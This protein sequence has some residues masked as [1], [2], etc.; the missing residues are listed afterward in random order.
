MT[1]RPLSAPPGERPPARH[2]RNLLV[3]AATRRARSAPT[4]GRLARRRAMI[5]LTKWVLPACALALLTIV[6]IWPE[7]DRATDQARM[8]FR[9]L[10]AEVEGGRLVNARYRGVDE[11]DRPY[12]VTAATA[13]QVDP[14][15]IDMTMPKADIEMENGSWLMLQSRLGSY[16]QATQ[17]LELWQDVTL[18]RDDGTTLTTAAVSIDLKNGVAASGEPTHVEGPFGVLDAQGFTVI[19]K[20]EAIQFVGPAHVILNGASP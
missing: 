16:R 2:D 12:T 8:S 18:Y 5:T 10:T 6:A 15:R 13:R 20:G 3:D 9:R 11:K 7:L 4:P 14:N 1:L 19:D 17:Q